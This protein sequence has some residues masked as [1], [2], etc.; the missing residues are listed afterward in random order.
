MLHFFTKP[1]ILLQLLFIIKL[2]NIL[3]INR[4]IGNMTNDFLNYFKMLKED[5]N[6]AKIFIKD[7]DFVRMMHE[8][9]RK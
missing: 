9:K 6:D 8:L 1:F 5:A 2:Q 4:E 3:L 7:N